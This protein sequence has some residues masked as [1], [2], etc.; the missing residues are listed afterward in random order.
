MC[1][2]DVHDNASDGRTCSLLEF[3][4]E[5]PTA[6]HSVEQARNI[7]NSNGFE[8]LKESNEWVLNPGDRFYVIRS[9]TSIVAGIPGM[10]SPGENGF[11]II[12]AH[13]DAPGFRVKPD[14]ERTT[15]SLTT[16]GVE[17][18]G[19]PI[20][21]TWFDRDLGI[22]GKLVLESEGRLEQRLFDLR[23]PLCRM[24][25]PAV[26][27]NRTV[28]KEGFKVNEEDNLP[29]IL[30]G[31]EGGLDRLL[32]EAAASAGVGREKIASWSMEPYDIQP[33]AIGGLDREFVFSGRIDNAAMCH[34]ALE[35]LLASGNDRQ[36][37]IIAL[38]DSE[39]VGSM[40]VNGAGSGFIGS[41][42][43]RLCSSRQQMF[44]ALARSILVSA[45][46]AHA[47]HPNYAD[48]HDRKNRPRLN[49]GPVIKI[50]AGEKYTT[51]PLTSAYFSQCAKL[52]GVEVQTYVNRSDMPC[53]TTIGPITATRT[54]IPTVDV[55]NP[56]LSMHSV[57]EM[58]GVK[59]HSYMIRALE[60][61][62]NGAVEIDCG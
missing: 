29:P 26:H 54:G 53:G 4:A 33:P 25:T 1:D 21:A 7:L 12:G 23:R 59:D 5:S 8:E 32:E 41:I 18:Y 48:K 30:T 58:A 39:E 11:R 10:T 52:A 17:V 15:D 24:T 40:T 3:L 51:T 31:I 9:G 62:L 14:P 22:A 61:H 16:L 20:L 2:I 27:L 6:A 57:R 49:G 19:G 28:N 46:G 37:R 45:D 36:S 38:F 43:E 44:R 56:M 35:A 42:L 47:V 55:G 34:A 60:V 13:T 50:N